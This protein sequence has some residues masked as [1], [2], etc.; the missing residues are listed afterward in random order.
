M[1]SA[2]SQFKS[3][4][5][6]GSPAATAANELDDREKDDGADRCVDD[7][8]RY[9]GAQVNIQSRQQ[10]IADKRADDSDDDVTDYAEARTSHDQ[11]G[12]PAGYQTDDENDDETF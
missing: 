6:A 10:P 8:G 5:A 9:S 4:S 11:G 3:S 2:A 1:L 7:R 12:Q